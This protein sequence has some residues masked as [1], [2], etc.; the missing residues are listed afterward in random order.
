MKKYYSLREISQELNIP[1]STLV[2]YKDAFAQFLPFVGDGKRKKLSEEGL[3][4]LREV[5]DLRE[6]EKHD[7]MEIRDFLSEKYAPQ[8]P[9]FPGIE[10]QMLQAQPPPPPSAPPAMSSKQLEHLNHLLFA[11]AGEMVKNREIL[12]DIENSIKENTQ[13][14]RHLESTTAA[15][16]MDIRSVRGHVEKAVESADN[17]N[18]RRFDAVVSYIRSEFLKLNTAVNGGEVQKPGGKLKEL[19]TLVKL[20]DKIEK[21][22][23]NAAL[24]QAMNKLLKRENQVLRKKLEGASADAPWG[25]EQPRGWKD[26]FKR[27]K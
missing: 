11:I 1:K 8:T 7:W 26:V 27:R 17:K 21:V 25:K 15:A 20:N 22:I 24:N 10:P 4:I 23:E 19:E 14:I 12:A 13:R 16:A 2:K 18:R 6:N 3:E 9:D 5:R